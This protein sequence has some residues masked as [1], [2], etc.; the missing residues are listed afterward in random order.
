MKSYH[1]H[2]QREF[3]SHRLSFEKELNESNDTDDNNY[4]NNNNFTRNEKINLP[5]HD[6]SFNLL[7]RWQKKIMRL[8][9]R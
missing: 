7:F 6:F 2:Y 1:L 9:S 3:S 8:F 5:R 4:N